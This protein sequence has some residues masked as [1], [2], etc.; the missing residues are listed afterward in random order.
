MLS[1]AQELPK[2]VD[3]VEPE[4]DVEEE[5]KAAKDDASAANEPFEN[6]TWINGYLFFKMVGKHPPPRVRFSAP[7]GCV[8]KRTSNLVDG[9]D[10]VIES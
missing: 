3:A 1:K 7:F 6:N 5:A 2:D 10:M 9:C 8:Q 4:K